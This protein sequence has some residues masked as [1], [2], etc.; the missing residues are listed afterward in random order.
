M[1]AAKKNFLLP[2]LWIVVNCTHAWICPVP[3]WTRQCTHLHSSPLPDDYQ[4]QGT[5]LIQRAAS[6]LGATVDIEWKP[7]RIIVQ[8]NEPAYLSPDPENNQPPLENDN[9]PKAIMDETPT[10]LGVDVTVLA[11]AINVALDDGDIG[12]RIAQT[13]EI[14]VTTPGLSCNQ[15]RGQVMFDAY[16]GFDV[17]VECI[18][19]KTKTGKTIN[20]RL[21]ERNDSVTVVNIKGRIKK[22]KNQDVVSVKLPK[23]K[24]EKGN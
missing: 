7:A 13:H 12:E 20:G 11:R 14:E 1:R 9:D 3:R 10:P 8:V 23:A 21:V 4:E 18:D 16:R 5:L 6:L 19:A 15:L 22:I 2:F 24:K 17:L